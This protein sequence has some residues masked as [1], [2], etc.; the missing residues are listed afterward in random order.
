MIR[1]GIG[2]DA[3]RLVAGRPLV[4]GGV[5]IEFPRGLEGHSD[6]DVLCH[7]VM[8]ALL[9]AVADGDIGQHFPDTDAR[10]KDACSLDLL[11]AVGH[12]LRARHAT[13]VNLDVTMIAERPK[14]APH[15]PAMRER[16][17]RALDV[18]VNRVSVK[19]TTV[20]RLGALGREEG[21]AALCVATVDAADE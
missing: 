13:I 14:L 2:F 1:T 10:W 11:A 5:M 3:H 17:A 16:M 20:E 15:I 8:D 18:T 6:A 9:G 21:M 19:A 12:R 4:L 7:A